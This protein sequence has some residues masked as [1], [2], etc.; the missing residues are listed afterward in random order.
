MR[1]R[2]YAARAERENPS[3]N[4]TCR[5]KVFFIFYLSSTGEVTVLNLRDVPRSSMR[6][7]TVRI[8][9]VSLC[10]QET[11]KGIFK[12][13]FVK[14]INSEY[15]QVERNFTLNLVERKNKLHLTEKN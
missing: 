3:I 15:F 5:I 14:I 10:F 2:E 12:N 11:V 6:R 8:S 4:K 13:N 9:D 1:V 7:L